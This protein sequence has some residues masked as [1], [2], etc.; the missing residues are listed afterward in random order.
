MFN[1]GQMFSKSVKDLVYTGIAGSGLIVALAAVGV[2]VKVENGD[3]TVLVSGVALF[4]AI[5]TAARNYL[6]H[7]HNIKLPF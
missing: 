1:F 7:K 3:V 2:N 5:I 4:S 6:A